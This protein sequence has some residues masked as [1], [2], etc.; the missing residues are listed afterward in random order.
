MKPAAILLLL[1]ALPAAA[2]ITPEAVKTAL[3]QWSANTKV[4]ITPGAR[5]RITAQTLEPPNRYRGY[6]DRQ[7]DPK[8]VFDRTVRMYCFDLRDLSGPGAKTIEEKSVEKLSFVAFLERAILPFFDR[9]AGYVSVRSIP[10][11]GAIAID[12]KRRGFADRSFVLDEGN[13]EVR[14]TWR[15]SQSACLQKIFVRANQTEPVE[16]R[17]D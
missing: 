11:E 3:D 12:G 17:R 16:C 14:V 5:Q 6:L 13:H 2:Q 7:K 1:S 4:A 10:A 8:T 9:A 15:N